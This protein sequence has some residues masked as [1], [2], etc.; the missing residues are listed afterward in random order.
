MDMLAS[1]KIKSTNAGGQL[2]F[3]LNSEYTMLTSTDC[4]SCQYSQM[5][6]PSV[7]PAISTESMSTYYRDRDGNWQTLSGNFYTEDLCINTVDDPNVCLPVTF[8]ALHETSLPIKYSG[9][10]GLMNSDGVKR[11]F[12]SMLHASKIIEK[13]VFGLWAGPVNIFEA[14]VSGRCLV[15]MITL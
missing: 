9:K 4:S 12:T 8:L 2:A 3:D 11:D 6:D 15:I 13:Q 10:I 7:S 5:F 1:V 14:D